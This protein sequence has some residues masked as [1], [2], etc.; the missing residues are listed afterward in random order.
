MQTFDQSFFDLYKNGLISYEDALQ[1]AS[2]PDDFVLKVK[3]IQSTGEAWREEGK[4]LSDK[5]KEPEIE[6]F[7]R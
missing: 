1:R 6:R 4:K 3:G 7:S 2:N 5:K